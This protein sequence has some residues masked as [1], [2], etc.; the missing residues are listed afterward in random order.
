ML[1]VRL[2]EKV[3]KWT[4]PAWSRTREQRVSYFFYSV[5]HRCAL[6]HH[7]TRFTKYRTAW[8]LLSVSEN[9]LVF[10]SL[11]WQMA[12]NYTIPRSLSSC[13]NGEVCHRRKVVS[14]GEHRALHVAAAGAKH[15]SVAA[16]VTFGFEIKWGISYLIFSP[17]V[18]TYTLSWHCL[19]LQLS[20]TRPFPKDFF[21]YCH[22][23]YYSWCQGVRSGFISV[24][25]KFT[26]ML[27]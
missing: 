22:I 14:C 16:T 11:I 13:Y 24:F 20:S 12:L 26:R 2:K 4:Q 15:N 19:L 7:S 23:S 6:C 8:F 5:K 18:F 1:N 21:D 10:V 27:L 17:C 25:V 3:Q 9:L